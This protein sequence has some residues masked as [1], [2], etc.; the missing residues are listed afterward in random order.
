MKKILQ[1]YANMGDIAEQIDSLEDKMRYKKYKIKGVGG[2]LLMNDEDIRYMIELQ[3]ARIRA[4]EN[5]IL[6]SEEDTRSYVQDLRD[7]MCKE[8][9]MN[10][11]IPCQKDYAVMTLYKTLKEVIV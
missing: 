11:E 2:A 9:N 1:M 8:C 3:W 7:S 10:N 5:A 6:N 4:L